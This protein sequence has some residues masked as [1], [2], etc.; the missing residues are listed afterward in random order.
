MIT[1]YYEHY[2]VWTEYTG[3]LSESLCQSS[4][5]SMLVS[6]QNPESKESNNTLNNNNTYFHLFKIYLQT[7]LLCI[8]TNLCFHILARTFFP[9]PSSTFPH[10]PVHHPHL[11]PSS[12]VP[13]GIP[14]LVLVFEL[15][16]GRFICMFGNRF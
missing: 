3:N 15:L 6:S 9:L 12:S 16:P 8:V 1:I 7:R 2:L 11:P 10:N 13:A 5:M 14:P 4:F